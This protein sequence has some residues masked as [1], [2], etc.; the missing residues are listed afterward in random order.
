MRSQSPS[1]KQ[2]LIDISMKSIITIILAFCVTAAT[3]QDLTVEQIISKANTAYRYLGDDVK[4]TAHMDIRDGSGRT[5]MERDLIILRKNT[6]GLQQKWYA[7]FQKPADIKRMVF[8]A[9]KNEGKDDDRWLYLPALD[10]VKR[11]SGSDKRSSFA[12]SQFAYEDVTGRSPSADT[13]ELMGQDA[14][15]YHIK[16]TPKDAGSVEFSHYEIW[17]DK[18]TFLPTK[19]IL[20][21]KS[22]APYKQYEMLEWK[23]VQGYPT[24]IK[25]SMTN[26][27]N[28]ES[29]IATM[30]DVEYN[31]GLPDRIFTEAS[32]RRAPRKYLR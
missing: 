27:Q 4:S 18:V 15:S 25:F 13:H 16:S 3:A 20:Y 23:E 1:L 24:I 14:D 8:M 22:A 12:G 5:I 17:I 19:T 26:L 11:L 2:L 21:D 28:G 31:L 32:L 9:V 30:S 10:L 6:G 7:Y 29:T